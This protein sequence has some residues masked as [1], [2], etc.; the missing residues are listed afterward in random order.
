MKRK[1]Q[2]I[3]YRLQQPRLGCAMHSTT[4]Y[5]YQTDVDETHAVEWRR[6]QGECRCETTTMPAISLNCYPRAIIADATNATADSL[7]CGE[8]FS[9]I[10]TPMASGERKA[11]MAFALSSDH[12]AMNK[13][14]VLIASVHK[15]YPYTKILVYDT[16]VGDELLQKKL[17][18]VRNVE[19]HP[20]DTATR[21]LS[22]DADKSQFNVLFMWQKSVSQ[23]IHTI[24]VLF[25][26]DA[27]SRYKTVLWLNDDLEFLSRNLDD[28]LNK[29]TSPIT[30][31]GREY[32]SDIRKHAFIPYFPGIFTKRNYTLLLLRRGAG[33]ALQWIVKCAAEPSRRC[34]DCRDAYEK[35]VDCMP[36]LLARLSLDTRLE[37]LPMPTNS[38]QHQRWEP[39]TCDARCVVYTFLAVTLFILIAI[40]LVL[41]MFSKA[42]N[43]S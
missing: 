32:T 22:D 12:T 16:D 43:K 10:S 42:T 35:A 36:S 3:Q 18:S 40:A 26:K 11:E 6:T 7:Q 34:W 19:V 8:C 5:Y 14:L 4:F 28:V 25:I 31:I 27:L 41:I 17:V 30:A 37:Y 20:V 39:T 21:F 2:N 13:L 1:E 15:H 33:K 23:K 9:C 24:I 38:V 29:T